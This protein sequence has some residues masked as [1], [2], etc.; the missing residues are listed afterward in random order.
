MG[1][2]RFSC[3]LLVGLALFAWSNAGAYETFLGPTGVI[4]WDKAK[5]YDG[6]TLYG[7][8]G[9]TN[10]YLIDKAGT[11]STNGRRRT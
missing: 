7:P 3:F 10:I 2:K 1:W 9:G 4:K 5:S 8:N 6:Y 11:S